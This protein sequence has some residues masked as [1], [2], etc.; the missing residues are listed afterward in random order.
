MSLEPI[1]KPLDRV[2]GRLKVTGAARFAAE[3]SP[4]RVVHAAFVQ[5]TITK[6]RITDIDTRVAEKAPGVLAV[7]THRNAPKIKAPPPNLAR[8]LSMARSAAARLDE[9]S[10]TR[11]DGSQS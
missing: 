11:S 4:E 10:S 5:S 1:G 7:L 3:Y 2:D 6:G 9:P 8:T